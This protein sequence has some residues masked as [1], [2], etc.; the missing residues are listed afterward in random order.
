MTLPRSA[1]RL[2]IYLSQT[3]HHRGAPDYV[4]IVEV[5]RK[6]GMAGATVVQ[7]VAGFGASS[8]VHRRHAMSLADEVPVV[9]MVVDTP[10]RI[11]GFLR[12]ITSLVPN[13]IAIRQS[14]EVAIHRSSS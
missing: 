9:V 14:V 5:A 3:E 6:V 8:T 11:D 12:D 2:T 7:G 13:A 10:D 1:E 4:K